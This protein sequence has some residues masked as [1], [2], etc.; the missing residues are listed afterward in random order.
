[1]VLGLRC[2]GLVYLAIF[3]LTF[4]C[5]FPALG[6]H[7]QQPD[8]PVVKEKWGIGVLFLAIRRAMLHPRSIGLYLLGTRIRQRLRHE[9]E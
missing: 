2:I 1:M 3:I 4:G 9:P 5:E 7:A 6:K 8:A